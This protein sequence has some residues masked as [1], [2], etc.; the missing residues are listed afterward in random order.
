VVVTIG[1][2]ALEC[3]AADGAAVD[4]RR[5]AE[6][7]RSRAV[8]AVP[9]RDEPLRVVWTGKSWTLSTRLGQRS[10]AWGSMGGVAGPESR[11]ENKPVG[12]AEKTASGHDG[13]RVTLDQ[14]AR[15]GDGWQGTRVAG[16]DR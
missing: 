5:R 11:K 3:A 2:G 7:T 15:P 4:W 1:S 8:A 16:E 14:G 10:S 6:E 12:E 9:P 13:L